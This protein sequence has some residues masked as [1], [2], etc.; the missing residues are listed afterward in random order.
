MRWKITSTSFDPVAT[1][2]SLQF[3]ELYPEFHVKGVTI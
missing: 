1:V 2:F 3:P